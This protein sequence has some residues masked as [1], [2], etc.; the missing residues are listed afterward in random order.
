MHRIH[1]IGLIAAA[2][3][4]VAAATPI[5]VPVDTA[6]STLTVELC[7]GSNCDSDASPVA[8]YT[9]IKLAPIAAP[10][11]MTLYDFQYALTEPIDLFISAGI[12]G[13][14][15]ATGNDIQLLY[16]SPGTPLP[17]TVVSGG[18]FT[19]ENVPT[20]SEG[21]VDYSAT[22]VYCVALQS[23]NP[24]LPC[25]GTMDLSQ[26]GTDTGTIPGTVFVSP[27]REVTLTMNV[28]VTQ[29]IDSSNPSA[30]TMTVSG[31]IVG[32]AAVPLR[33]DANLDGL[34]D[35]RDIQDAVAVLLDPASQ[36]W[37]RRFA[38]DMNDDDQFDAAD[39]LALAECLLA[40]GCP[41]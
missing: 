16:P 21:F 7:I 18:A 34:V 13:H 10:T 3:V 25:V 17:P 2:I 32:H 9:I 41:D 8:G 37:Q 22:G 4:Q 33:G 36:S 40:H 29:P 12:L 39:A 35:A 23:L 11:S 5:V 30:G 24:P 6:Q 28:N 20:N 1:L 26:Q 38:V 31:P 14:F 27:G 19:Y 15:A